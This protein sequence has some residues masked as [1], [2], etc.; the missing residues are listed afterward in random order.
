MGVRPKTGVNQ[1]GL[2]DEAGEDR[3]PESTVRPGS[4][5][6]TEVSGCAI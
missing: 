3:R 4:R 5:C 6:G 1:E 2:R